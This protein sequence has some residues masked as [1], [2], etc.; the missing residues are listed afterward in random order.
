MNVYYAQ[1]A[2]FDLHGNFA[3]VLEELKAYVDEKIL[4]PFLGEISLSTQNTS[5]FVEVKESSGGVVTV[6]NN[7]LT[8][9]TLKLDGQDYQKAYK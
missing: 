8:T 2:F 5:Y 7:R 6:D 3:N 9:I 4:E 1:R